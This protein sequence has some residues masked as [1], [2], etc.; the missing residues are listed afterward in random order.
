M[1]IGILGGTFDPVHNGHLKVAEEVRSQ[2]D[3]AKVLFVPA[4]QP[5]LKSD[6]L[7]SPA[8]HRVEMVRL[9]ITGYYGFELSL[10]EI[11]RPG[12]SY[13]VDT[14]E[15]LRDK[16]GAGN[17]LFFILGWDSLSQLPRWKEPTRII[18]LCCLVAVPR[19]GYKAPDIKRLEMLIP[20]LSSRLILTDKPEIDISAT[21]IRRRVAEGLSITDLVPEAVAG[22]IKQHRMYACNCL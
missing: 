10:M 17:E 19:P 22:Y 4:G 2:L 18:E 8:K 1:K 3:L 6:S 5:W 13:T 14:I 21:Q 20:G 11:N 15:E 16:N 9:A 7:V 12:L